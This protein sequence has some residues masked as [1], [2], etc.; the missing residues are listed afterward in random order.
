MTKFFFFLNVLPLVILRGQI[1]VET[2]V[3]RAERHR[4]RSPT[5]IK[6][7]TFKQIILFL[8]LQHFIT[9]YQMDYLVKMEM[10]FEK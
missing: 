3:M 4:C 5:K 6:M 7:Y 2:G 9:Q 8:S 10:R 1:F